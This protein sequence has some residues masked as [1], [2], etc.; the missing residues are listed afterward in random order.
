MDEKKPTRDSGKGYGRT[1][2]KIRESSVEGEFVRA[3]REAGG[4]ALK[5]TSQTMNGLPDRLILCSGAKAYFVELKAPGKRMCPLQ[6]KRRQELEAMGFPVFCVDRPEQIKPL[7]EAMEKWKLGDPI[8]K[9]LGARIP[10]LKTE[11]LPKDNPTD[12]DESSFDK[13]GG[14]G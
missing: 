8:P 1:S 6:R 3:V 9:G 2:S 14:S 13:G 11:P 5:L 10:E 12:N 7:I 4:E